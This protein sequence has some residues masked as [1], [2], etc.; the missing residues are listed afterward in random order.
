MYLSGGHKRN[1]VTRAAICLLLLLCTLIP[2]S[3]SG[4]PAPHRSFKLTPAAI[5][6]ELLASKEN[7][8]ASIVLTDVPRGLF[9]E[10]NEKKAKPIAWEPSDLTCILRYDTAP[11]NR[12]ID[13]NYPNTISASGTGSLIL[14]PP[15][16][17][18]GA[19]VY[20][21][22]LVAESDSALTSVEFKV[23]VQANKSPVV[24]APVGTISLQ[25]GTPL[26]RWDPVR[27]VPYYSVFLSEGPI[28]IERDE[29]GKV[30]GLSGLALTWQVITAESFLR[31][32][33][34]DPGGNFA[35][36]H[37]PPLLPGIEYNWVILN[38]YGPNPDLISGDVAPLAPAFFEVRRSTLPQA[39]EQVQPATAA[40]LTEDEIVFEWMPVPDATRYRIFLYETAQFSNNEILYVLWSQVTTD[41][42]LTL[43]TRDFLIK[44]RYYWRIVAENG[45]SLS[46]SERRPF[47]YAGA[48][49]WAEF[50]INSTEGPMSRVSIKIKNEAEGLVLLPALTDTF[51]VATIPLPAGNYTFRASRPG[52]VTTPEAAFTVLD[53]DTTLI[54]AQLE[55]GASTISGRVVDA[56]GF[57]IFDAEV[58]LK[59]GATVDNI[60]CDEGGYFT[61]SVAPGNWTLRVRKAGF[62]TSAAQSFAVPNGEA[63]AAGDILLAEASN[64]VSG[65]V[66]FS[67]DGRPLQGARIR[68]QQADQ[69]VET[70]TGNQGGYR[71]KLGPGKWRITLDPQGFPASP[72]AYEFDLTENQQ[73][74]ADFQLFSGVLVYGKVTFQGLGVRDA[75]VRVYDQSNGEL[76]QMVLSNVQGNYSLGLPEGTYEIAVTRQNFL[77]VRQA[78]AITGD[79]A[80]VQN[81]QLTEAGFVE[82][83]VISLE[84]AAPV[85][86]V[87]IFV[88]EDSTVHTFSDV[89][90]K[91]FLSLPPNILF[92]IDAFVPGFGSNGPLEV[93]T[94]SGQRL[95][96]Q[97][98]FLTALSGIVRGQVTDGFSPLPE[99][100]VAIEALDLEVLTDDQ[101][102]F[103]FEISPGDYRIDV[104]KE[105]HF[106]NSENVNLAAGITLDLQI[107][108][109]PLQSVVTGKIVDSAGLPIDA[110]EI[111][112]VSDTTFT[113]FSDETGAYELCLNS[114]IFRV[115][116]SKPGHFSDDTTLVINEGDFHAGIDFRLSDSF[117]RLTGTV[118]DSSG[119]AVDQATV[120]LRNSDQAQTAQTAADG[121]FE[122]NRIIPGLYTVRALQEGLFGKA[123]NIFL[124]E[125]QQ[126]TVGLILFPADGFIR[127]TA[128]D[129]SDG[130]GIADVTIS[131]QF[132]ERPDEFFT[133]TTDAEGNYELTALPVIPNSTYSVFAFK[134]GFFSPTPVEN[135]GA[136]AEGVDFS[137]VSKIGVIAGT[138]QD[139]DTSEPI[140]GGRIEAANNSGGRSLAFTDSTGR[141]TLL[142]LVPSE[143]YNLLADRSG[144]FPER[145][146]NLVPGDTSLTISMLRK[147][148]FVEGNVSNISTTAPASGVL[149]RATPIGLS[150][151]TSEVL[152]DAAGAFRLRLVADFYKIQPLLSHHRSEPAFTQLEV[153]EVDTLSNIDFTLEAQTVSSITIRRADQ[154]ERP[155]ISNSDMHCYVAAAS[156]ASNRPVNIGMPN[157]RLEASAKAATIGPDGCIAL[158]PSYFGD[159]TIVAEDQASGKVGE[160]TVQV[161]AAVDSTT[162]VLLFDDRGLEMQILPRA[163]LE[164]QN[165]L[166][167]RIELA[168]AKKSRAELFT[169]DYSFVIKP[170]GLS[171]SGPVTL[172]LP[173]PQNTAGQQR[174]IARWDPED[175]AWFL[176]VSREVGSGL[177]EANI[178]E[179]GEYIALALSKPLAVE[180]LKLMPNPFSPFREI[181]GLPGL[182]IEFEV[183][184][185]AAP[186]PLLT[187][188][189]YN[190]EGN[191][192]RL[193]RDQRPVPRGEIAVHW[194]GRTDDGA[195]ARNGRYLVRVIVEDPV[196]KED[197]MKSVILIK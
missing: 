18:M 16:E 192:V 115:T 187:V 58:E 72:P 53:N 180:N 23:I 69:K 165:L 102:R 17:G 149:V 3:V 1:T 32:G 87:R 77:E 112:A 182:K 50:E 65:Q 78:L 138:V 48:A 121:S 26:F 97:D 62:V 19:G 125:L 114:G 75:E 27:G 33:D 81:F 89:D 159:L 177:I 15:L 40:V 25:Q 70:T 118:L 128:R 91:Y 106:S 134:E 120:E 195:L 103:Q 30:T 184:S 170:T 151:R 160:L 73:M 64:T 14:N 163:V 129:A 153:A 161:F 117:A 194:D 147:Y 152:T 41:T 93:M 61:A 168:P 140:A 104:Q 154:T 196:E 24:V 8:D 131:A 66:T 5:N 67:A 35:N 148:G 98:F 158:N 13:N 74:G 36:V 186:N 144:Y 136:K 43:R 116:A 22:I 174:H 42:R 80:V 109:Q 59:S 169:T 47:D 76:R 113:V 137:L 71:F 143:T 105:C 21:C 90:G 54:D 84:S 191:L 133:T 111:S 197:E 12:D 99:A 39:P 4:Q 110:A 95:T 155:A 100:Q 83:R 10:G 79:A 107:V 171:F 173:A 189:I 46:A 2:L 38:S 68:A 7:R 82:G 101:G 145:L 28:S 139:T 179:T 156:D 172:T 142:N 130:T 146:Q 34:L 164:R 183:S 176:L 175:S 63:I 86:G 49:G 51:G 193:L 94:T 178:L 162:E 123:E 85:E 188:K 60:R 11:G 96:G 57:G 20:Y 55:R 119:T 127:G 124:L 185:D 6:S 157:W 108:L 135:L 126:F 29:S 167:S 45:Q 37:V 92:Q 141:F 88:V 44:T 150:G 9:L 122:I 190:L 166:V 31:Y 56:S 181:D 132:S 52:F